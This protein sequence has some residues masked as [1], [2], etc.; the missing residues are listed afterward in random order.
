MFHTG[1]DGWAIFS[2]S[3]LFLPRL[4]C[5]L[6][7]RPLSVWMKPQKS[8]KS[9]EPFEFY[10]LFIKLFVFSQM[11]F[12]NVFEASVFLSWFNSSC[13]YHLTWRKKE[14]KYISS[15]MERNFLRENIERRCGH[16]LRIILTLK[17]ERV[18][19]ISFRLTHMSFAT[20]V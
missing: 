15:V 17:H 1:W 8:S 2:L 16:G 20:S 5:C 7:Y 18:R 12:S 11:S 14:K 9:K 4:V 19:L 10:N 6:Q 3:R 13:V